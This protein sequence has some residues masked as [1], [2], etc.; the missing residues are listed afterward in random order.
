MDVRYQVGPEILT[1]SPQ[2]W[3]VFRIE[4]LPSSNVIKT[5]GSTPSPLKKLWTA[6]VEQP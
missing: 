1:P 4:S 5:H 2:G 6:K 3:K